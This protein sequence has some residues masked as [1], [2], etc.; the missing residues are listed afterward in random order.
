MRR[1][2]CLKSE[3]ARERETVNFEACS[4]QL[5]SS[6]DDQG[7]EGFAFFG[8]REQSIAK[9]GG[10]CGLTYVRTDQSKGHVY[11]DYRLGILYIFARRSGSRLGWAGLG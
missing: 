1:A 8:T 6:I 11:M 10:F 7:V 5:E 4:S 2:C 3:R 9:F